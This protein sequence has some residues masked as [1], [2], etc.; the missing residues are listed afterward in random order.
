MLDT[1]PSASSGIRYHRKPGIPKSKVKRGISKPGT[2]SIISRLA[3]PM[4]CTTQCAGLGI[5][6]TRFGNPLHRKP[7]IPKPEVKRGISKPGTSSVISRLANPML[8]TTQCA[9][10][11]IRYRRKPGIP[12]PK[13]KRGISKP[14][15]SSIISRLANPMLCTTQCAGL[16]IRSTRFGNPLHRK[17]GIPKPKVKRGISEPGK[18][19]IKLNRGLP[20]CYS[21]QSP[22]PALEFTTTESQKF[23][24]P[25]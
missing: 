22:A 8:C 17:P 20:I 3:N 2:S 12:K 14:S 23:L 1:N 21:T 9:G 5:R 7:G 25:K 4:L 10:L 24:S 15:T 19:T 6:S 18:R 11:G 13:V 16:G